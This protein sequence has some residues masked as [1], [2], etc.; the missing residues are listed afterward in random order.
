MRVGIFSP[1][2]QTFGGGERYVLTAADFFLQRGDKVDIFW[3]GENDISKIK[4]R[5]DIDLR[6]AHFVPDI[7]QNGSSFL[8]KLRI[9]R[10][11]D[12]I[13][14]L[15]DGSIPFSL[16]SRNILHF[17]QPFHYENQN[18]LATKLK[19]FRF[20]AVICNSRF[21]KKYVDRTYGIKSQ[22]VYPPVDTLK[23]SSGKKE[24]VI[25][26]VGRFF[27][28]SPPK[29]QEVLIKTF[30]K[31][32][33]S[34]F[35][36][37]KLILV[38]GVT[39]SSEPSLERLTALSKKIPVEI[40]TDTTFANLKKYY[41]LA[42][43]Y[44]HATGYGEDLR[45]FPEKAEHFGITT[46]EAMAAGCVPIVFAGGGQKEIVSSGKNGFFWQTTA[47]LA[48]RTKT[49]ADDEKL[50]QKISNAAITRSKFFTK[51]KFFQHLDEIL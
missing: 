35:R 39:P 2:F 43:V 17:Q 16:A 13:F 14:Y 50:R 25:L 24:N 32:F 47:E 4:D 7:F 45:N 36:D 34:G 42:K 46:V 10:N 40:V 49:L 38:G 28:P 20:N 51:E 19:L 15:S 18:N 29:K 21:T 41:S 37:W 33:Q 11:Y 8:N 48:R 12:V 31:M 6:K 44:W 5:F 1:Y 9:T 26:S 27:G 22:V 30:D 3:Q 23:F